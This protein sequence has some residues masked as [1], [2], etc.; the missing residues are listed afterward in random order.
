MKYLLYYIPPTP[1]KIWE[2]KDQQNTA[3]FCQK[4]NFFRKK[5]EL[6]HV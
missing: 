4:T 6:R 2:D 3:N 1:K 5:T